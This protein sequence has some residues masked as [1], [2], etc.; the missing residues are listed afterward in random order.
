MSL[1]ELCVCERVLCEKVVCKRVVC[2]KVACER[3][4]CVC[5]NHLNRCKTSTLIGGIAFP[6]QVLCHEYFTRRLSNLLFI[7]RG[8]ECASDVSIQRRRICCTVIWIGDAQSTYLLNLFHFRPWQPAK[9]STGMSF[10]QQFSNQTT[11]RF[12]QSDWAASEPENPSSKDVERFPSHSFSLP[13]IQPFLSG[14][15]EVFFARVMHSTS[16]IR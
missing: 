13:I 7:C 8:M 1:K 15:T 2:K 12:S 3:L 11:V 5:V 9:P 14:L 4:V 10:F 6:Y 16:V